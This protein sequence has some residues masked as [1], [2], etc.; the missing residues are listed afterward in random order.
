MRLGDFRKLI[1]DLPDDYILDNV[2]HA[3]VLPGY[4]DGYPTECISNEKEVRYIYT[5]EPKIRFIM[6]D[7]ELRFYDVCDEEKTYEENLKFVLRYFVRGCDVS[8]E[9]WERKI[10]YITNEFY[11]FWNSELWKETLTERKTDG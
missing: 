8:D 5:N 6:L 1:A 10:E 7:L 4:Y 11:Y 2:L 9:K 3:E